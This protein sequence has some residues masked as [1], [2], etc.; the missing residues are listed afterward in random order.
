MSKEGM[1]NLEVVSPRNMKNLLK[2]S[3][4]TGVAVMIWG[5]PGIGK[6]D[7]VRQL[8]DDLS[9]VD[10]QGEFIEDER[11][12]VYDVRLLL[13]EPTDL[14]GIPYRDPEENVMKWSEPTCLPP[15]KFKVVDQKTQEKVVIKNKNRSI[16][17]LDELTAA[18]PSVQGAAY[19]LILDRKIGDYSLPEGCIIVAAGNRMSD[20]GVS[21]KMPT[22]LRNRFSHFEMTHNYEEWLEWAIGKKVHPEI[23]G[24][25]AEKKNNGLFNFDPNSADCE[26][27]F[28]TPRSWK[29]LSDYRWAMDDQLTPDNIESDSLYRKIVIGCIGSGAASVFIGYREYAKDLP[30]VEDVLSGKVKVLKNKNT[31][32]HY[33]LSSSLVYALNEK[34]LEVK[35]NKMKKEEFHQ[36]C[37]NFL[38]F[39]MDNFEKEMVIMSARVGLRIYR[40][41]MLQDPKKVMSNIQRFYKDY[42]KLI[43][44]A[45]NS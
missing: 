28:P 44:K 34:W 20:K 38:G 36:V 15:Q 25:I 41:P 21:F 30:K 32:A 16:L 19:Q 42:G 37:D 5:P 4:K 13:M 26:R 23:I 33:F 27:G 12:P 45:V 14:R 29:F 8:A 31:S 2:I 11:V 3:A 24:F 9:P 18:P 1:Q 10:D 6:S 35:E 39:A 40:M 43:Q 7:I 17:F 22:P